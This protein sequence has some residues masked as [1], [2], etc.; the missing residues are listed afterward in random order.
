MPHR[1][2]IADL[3]KATYGALNVSAFT[4]L[5][6]GGLY[7]HVPQASSFPYARIDAAS[8]IRDDHFGQPGK[9]VLVQVHVFSQ[10]RGDLEA[11]DI[12]S[13]AIE[14]LHYVAH[15]VDN[16]TLVTMQYDQT[17]PAGDELLDGVLTGHWVAQFRALVEET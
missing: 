6:T 7:N 15:S 16:H 5:A 10:Y 14:L 9:S 1:T 17:T 2:A 3:L 4:N 13:K 12:V 8:E 11:L